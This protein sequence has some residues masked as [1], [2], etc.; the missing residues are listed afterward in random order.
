VLKVELAGDSFYGSTF[1]K[2]RIQDNWL[3]AAG[4][5]PSGRVMIHATAHGEIILTYIEASENR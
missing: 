4:F 2:I 3:A 1:P 5:K